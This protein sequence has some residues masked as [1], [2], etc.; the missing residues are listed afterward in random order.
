MSSDAEKKQRERFVAN[1]RIPDHQTDPNETPG[2]QFE[3]QEPGKGLQQTIDRLPEE[4]KMAIVL[5]GIQELSYD[6]IAVALKTSRSGQFVP[7]FSGGGS[8]SS[9]C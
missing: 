4:F 6:E 5:R 8:S 1:D 3:R 2:Q 9:R 7:E